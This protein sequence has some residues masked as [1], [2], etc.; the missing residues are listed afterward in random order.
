MLCFMCALFR[1]R[2][3][4]AQLLAQ[5]I[6]QELKKD[7]IHLETA[8]NSQQNLIVLA[9]PRGGVILG[10]VIAT[11]L[12][13]TMDVIV[14]R[15]IR[16][17]FIEEYAIG[18]VMPDG[19]YFLNENV[20]NFFNISDKYLKKEIEFQKL[21]IQRRLLEFRGRIDYDDQLKNKVVVLVDDG[22]ATGATIIASAEWIK[23]KHHCRYLILAVPVA[24]A[25]DETV[26]RLNKIVDKVIILHSTINFYA[27]G[28][29][30][31]HFEQV[32]DDEVKDIMRKY[33]I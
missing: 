15:K 28:Q 3:H 10:D 25:K 11:H 7:E 12:H 17:E 1:D 18:A 8:A 20:A 14:S 24:P 31:D 29:F 26:D 6:E 13:C 4:A 22:I 23:R 2:L 32:T 27:V 9:I 21:E 33:R 5:R 19:T 16:A 30:Y